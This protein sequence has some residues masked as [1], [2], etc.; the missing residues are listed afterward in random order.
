MLSALNDNIPLQVQ[1]AFDKLSGAQRGA[2]EEAMRHAQDVIGDV[3]ELKYVIENVGDITNRMSKRWDLSDAGYGYVY[4]KVKY[5]LLSLQSRYGFARD[6]VENM[7]KA[8]LAKKIPLS[9]YSDH[10]SVVLLKYAEAHA[11]LTVYNPAQFHAR[12]AAVALGR[13]DFK[14]AEKHLKVLKKYLRNGDIWTAYATLYRLEPMATGPT[15]YPW[16]R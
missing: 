10:V 1:L 11:A 16:P 12:E 2:P 7:R 9:L 15:P 6:V 8:A 4:P 5:T 3:S 14:A 13:M